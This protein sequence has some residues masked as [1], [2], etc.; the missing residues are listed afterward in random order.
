MSQPSRQ[1][2]EQQVDNGGF[3]L[4]WRPPAEQFSYNMGRDS[5]GALLDMLAEV[6][7]QT[8]H[9]EKKLSELEMDVKPVVAKPPK[10]PKRKS[11]QVTFNVGQLLTMPA[12]QLVKLFSVFSSDELKRQYSYS[13]ALIP[14]CDQNY[15]SFASEG[16]ARMSI[17]SHL[18][19]HLEFLKSNAESYASFTATA[20]KYAKPKSTVQNKKAKIQQTKKP[21]KETL[22]KENKDTKVGKSTNY[23]RKILSN[24]VNLK[25][26]ESN[27]GQDRVNELRETLVQEIKKEASDVKVLGD[28]S[29]YEQV[30]EDNANEESTS[31]SNKVPVNSPTNENIMLMVVESN[32]VCVKDPLSNTE[33]TTKITD[34]EENEVESMTLWKEDTYTAPDAFVPA[35]P[36]G[37]AKFIGT[38]KEE[39]EMA[40]ILIEKIRKKGNPTGNNLQ[41]RICDPPRSFTAPTTLVSHYRSHAGI[42]PYE[43]RICRA[44]FTRRHSLK[45]HMLIHQNQTRFTCADCGKK[46]RHPSH[47]REHRRRHTGEA[48]FGCEDCGQRFKTRNTYK[49]HLKTRHGKVLTITGEL[50]H[51]SE[52]D[53]KKVR[54]KN[55]RK[56]QDVSESMISETAAATES[57]LPHA[58]NNEY[59]DEQQVC[60]EDGPNGVQQAIDNAIWMYRNQPGA[61]SEKNYSEI[62]SKPTTNKTEYNETEIE[63]SFE[64]N[65]VVIAQ[66]D[67]NGALHF[68]NYNYAQDE[69]YTDSNGIQFSCEENV[70]TE[71]TDNAKPY[72][73]QEETV[74]EYQE[75]PDNFTEAMNNPIL[76]AKQEPE[77]GVFVLDNEEIISSD[78]VESSELKELLSTSNSTQTEEAM[79]TESTNPDEQTLKIIPCQVK[80]CDNNGTATLQLLKNSKIALLGN[81]AQS[82]NLIQNGK[83]HTI[84]LLASGDNNL[85][86]IDNGVIEGSKSLP[87]IAV[88]AE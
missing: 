63:N 65:E 18:A 51:L 44:V 87:V 41:C 35:K 3:H 58:R 28:H 56:K 15:T 42:K 7:S 49:R 19:E 45:Y 12:T 23:L 31:N 62:K 26:F 79:Q 2:R 75:C 66:T 46:F 22:N 53:S 55:R 64:N 14:G 38:S 74:V 77:D 86:E 80:V 78:V 40:L 1:C 73:N 37:K 36:K 8:L 47:F 69:V 70:C 85:L 32:G 84:L 81:K 11:Q 88:P 71:I 9:S 83:Q 27:A 82:I 57:V 17:K 24:D 5:P 52:E 39:R 76:T 6:A 48:P 59:W 20:V 50:L 29:Y 30:K 16:R 4:T 67:S 10:E 61:A 25:E 21:H 68:E 72:E 13:C 43:C 60:N 54:T 34:A 33:N